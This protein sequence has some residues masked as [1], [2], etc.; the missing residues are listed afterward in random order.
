M[1]DVGMDQAMYDGDS[2]NLVELTLDE[3]YL[4]GSPI[5]LCCLACLFFT[6]LVFVLS[7]I[8]RNYSQTDKMYVC[9][10]FC[11]FS[12]CGKSQRYAYRSQER[13]LIF[14]QWLF[15]FLQLEYHSFYIY[16]DSRLWCE[17]TPHGND[18]HFVGLPLD[19]EFCQTWGLLLAAMGGRRGLSMEVSPR[20]FSCRDTEKQG[21]MDP[22]QLLI[23]FTVSAS[24]IVGGRSAF[25]GCPCCRHEMR[26]EQRQYLFFFAEWLG[27]S[28]LP[29]VSWVCLYGRGCW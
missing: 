6:S 23:H 25:D 29:F 4:S 26:F 19:L 1:S 16:L 24:L 14:L 21:C 11:N 17:N 8:S 9:R 2:C 7:E 12:S 27:H 3:L 28:R 5:Q 20:R 10:K 15:Y 18:F 22:L 13:T